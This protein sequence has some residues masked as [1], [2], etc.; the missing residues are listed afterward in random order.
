MSFPYQPKFTRTNLYLNYLQRDSAFMQE[1]IFGNKAEIAETRFQS[2]LPTTILVHG[3]R[4]NVSTQMPQVIKN[5]KK[6]FL[7]I[8]VEFLK[9]HLWS[10]Q[11]T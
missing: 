10:L 1:L 2:Q 3:F 5:G 4:N 8:R 11:L 7:I 6:T 9:L